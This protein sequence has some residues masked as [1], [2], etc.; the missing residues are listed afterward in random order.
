MIKH[1]KA[2]WPWHGLTA[3]VLIGLAC[4]LLYATSLISYEWHWNRVPQ[5]F[6]YKAEEAQRAAGYGKV[7]SIRVE[8]DRATV[9]LLDEE[10]AEQALEVARD[11]LQL[12]QGDDVAEGDLIGVTRHWAAGPLVWGL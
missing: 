7:E 8:G 1:K 3:L 11:S 6:A 9:V 10:G 12:E 2:Q 5:Y 4:S